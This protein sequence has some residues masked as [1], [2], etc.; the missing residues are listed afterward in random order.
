M[1]S[2]FV[3]LLIWFPVLSA[4]ALCALWL[5]LA[6]PV[7][8]YGGGAVPG[9]SAGLRDIKVCHKHP[10]WLLLRLMAS[11][12]LCDNSFLRLSPAL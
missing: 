6:N 11:L 4:A 12:H 8:L 5:S 7:T 9:V 3:R 2:P 1:K 10:G